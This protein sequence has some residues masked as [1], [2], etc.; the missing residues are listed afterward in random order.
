[1]S[2]RESKVFAS[3]LPEKAKAYYSNA[4]CYTF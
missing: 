2:H 4:S 3:A 1:M